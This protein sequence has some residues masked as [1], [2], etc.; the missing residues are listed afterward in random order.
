MSSFAQV[1]ISGA[2]DPTAVKTSTTY[3]GGANVAQTNMQTNGLTTSRIQFDLTEDLGG[4]LKAIARFEND[5]YANDDAQ[6]VGG[7]AAAGGS[8]AAVYTT[9]TS[10]PTP[11]SGSPVSNFGSAGGEI[12]TGL[13]GSFGTIKLGAPNTP[14]LGVQ[15]SNPF[16]TKL[17]GGYGEGLLG[18]GHV[19]NSQ[20]ANYTSGVFG[21]GFTFAY[22]HTFGQTADANPA[23]GTTQTNAALAAAA[24][25]SKLSSIAAAGTA[26][27]FGLTYAQGPLTG[28]IAYYKLG[29]A[30]GSTTAT[31]VEN[32]LTSYFIGY[33]TGD[34]LLQFGGHNE[35]AA[36]NTTGVDNA[37]TYVAAT[38]Q[39]GAALFLADLTNYQDKSTFTQSAPLNAR[40]TGLGVNYSLSKNT[41]VYGRYSNYSQDNITATGSVSRQQKTAAGIAVNF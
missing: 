23:T 1:V 30:N 12:Y 17:G 16:G 21:G 27:D 20:T 26:D 11:A 34:L 6:H 35:A 28:G 18:T 36:A 15:S 41:T 9:S 4:G 7:G 32:R 3:G 40:M 37:G 14:T 22:A 2:F 24:S 33:K 39:V 29:V 8:G 10:I 31:T 19:R 13:T 38:Y 25:S 5:F